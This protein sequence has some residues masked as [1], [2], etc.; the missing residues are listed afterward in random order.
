MDHPTAV[1]GAA[2]PHRERR[3]IPADLEIE[4]AI[5]ALVEARG[6]TKSVCPSEAA[7]A[8][9][10]AWQPL[11]GPVRRVAVQLARAGRIH[12]LR[13]GKPVDPAEVRGVIR[14]RLR[15]GPPLETPSSPPDTRIDP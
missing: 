7:R 15:E 4:A 14:L 11:M 3:T 12:I 1:P 8:L 5:L 6:P 10:P 13:K 9:A 2:Q